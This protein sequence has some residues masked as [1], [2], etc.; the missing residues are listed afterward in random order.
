MKDINIC[1]ATDDNYVQLAS[2]SIQ[3][4]LENNSNNKVNIFILDSG[5]SKESKDILTSQV[6]NFNQNIC[7]IDVVKDIKI[8]ADMGLNSQGK[9]NSFAAYARFFV[10]D[11]L[12]D[13]VDKILYVD[14]DTCI[15][16]DLKDLFE[17]D[18]KDNVLG[19]VIDILPSF[20][21]EAIGFDKDDKYFNSGVLLFNCKIWKKEKYLNKII[22]HLKKYGVK[23]SFHDQDIINIVCK[24]RILAMEPKYMVFLPEYIWGRNRI[25]KFTD[26]TSKSYYKKEEIDL[27]SENPVIIHYVESI[28]G[29]PWFAENKCE[30]YKDWHKY[31]INSPFS[32]NFKYYD[33]KV[34]LGHKIL[35]CIYTCLP[36]C[37][38]LKIYKYRKNKVLKKR[39]KI[40]R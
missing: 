24:N 3:S 23:Y 17:I 25:L 38:S 8:L 10:I 19:A 5:I 20:H 6:K 39:E 7:F 13:Y 18:L 12:P 1:L 22:E 27:A 30:L 2:V 29:R 9:N 36:L 16:S 21:K 32:N 31:L 40:A 35:V 15:C 37:I 28:L 4:I 14:C 33:K 34:S 11:N 26:L